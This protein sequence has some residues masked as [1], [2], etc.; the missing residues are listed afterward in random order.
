MYFFAQVKKLSKSE[1]C[2]F[3]FYKEEMYNYIFKR[4]LLV[5][6]VIKLILEPDFDHKFFDAVEERQ[7]KSP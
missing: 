7:G 3:S 5:K 2:L 1:K 4:S 6:K